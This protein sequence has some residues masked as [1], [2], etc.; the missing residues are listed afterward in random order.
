MPVDP[1]S[2]HKCRWGLVGRDRTDDD[3]DSG[4]ED[5]KT[6]ADLN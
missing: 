4:T 2:A 6:I 3:D 1:P 5:Q